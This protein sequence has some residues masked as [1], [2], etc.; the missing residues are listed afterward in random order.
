[1][2]ACHFARRFDQRRGKLFRALKLPSDEK[3][4]SRGVSQTGAAA[5]GGEDLFRQVL[6]PSPE[7]VEAEPRKFGP[8]RP[9]GSRNRTSADLARMVRQVGGDPVLAMARIAGMSLLQI[10]EMLGCTR[11]EAFDRWLMVLDKLAPYVN[12]KQPLAVAVSGKVTALNFTVPLGDGQALLGPD[13][14]ASLFAMG[15]ARAAAD[16]FEVPALPEPDQESEEETDG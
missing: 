2:T 1:L 15:A 12:S 5:V 4:A 11:V 9:P 16:G 14:V 7:E 10:K 6:A 8:G 13:A 3:D